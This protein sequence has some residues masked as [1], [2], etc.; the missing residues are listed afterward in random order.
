MKIEILKTYIKTYLKTGFIQ[1]S[2]YLASAP[3]PFDKK[4]D[5][6]L[7]PCVDY[8][9]KNNLTIKNQYLLPLIGEVLDKIDWREYFI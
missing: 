3:I 7:C 5:G 9:V 6:S 1:P 8:Q 4:G 2:K